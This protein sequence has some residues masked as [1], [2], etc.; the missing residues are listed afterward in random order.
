MHVMSSRV[1][2]GSLVL[3]VGTTVIRV[4]ICGQAM[5]PIS[6]HAEILSVW[7]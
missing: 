2:L 5:T 4:E 7:N 3:Y 1:I 6:R